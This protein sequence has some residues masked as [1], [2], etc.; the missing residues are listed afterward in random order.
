MWGQACLEDSHDENHDHHQHDKSDQ[1]ATEIH[2]I[3]PLDEVA[4]LR[5]NIAIR[6]ISSAGAGM[7]VVETTYR[8]WA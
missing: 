5:R 6:F 7:R 1:A 3:A 2:E 8:G 4:G